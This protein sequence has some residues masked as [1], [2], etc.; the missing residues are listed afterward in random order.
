ML[1]KCGHVSGIMNIILESTIP[2][3]LNE[4]RI[5]SSHLPILAECII[6]GQIH[7]KDKK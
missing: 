4:Q 1:E 5:Q 7:H 3:W 6:F 2:I